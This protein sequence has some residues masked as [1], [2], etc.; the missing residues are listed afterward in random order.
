MATVLLTHTVTNKRVVHHISTSMHCCEISHNCTLVTSTV[1]ESG[2]IV[3]ITK[4]FE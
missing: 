1:T 3:W 2:S 4:F